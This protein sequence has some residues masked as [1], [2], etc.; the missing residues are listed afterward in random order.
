VIA[1]QMIVQEEYSITRTRA[2][3]G[4]AERRRARTA[5][6]RYA[7]TLRIAAIVGTLTVC[8]VVYLGLMGN[9]ERMNYELARVDRE[10][11]ALVEK[12]TQ[13]D[14]TLARLRSRERLA[15]VAASLG[16]HEPQ[17]F[18]AI[19][20]PVEHPKPEPGGLAFLAKLR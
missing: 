4:A 3:R 9:V 8:V 13:L 18:A 15:R 2:A 12:S 14:D 17:T 11:A 5:R 10:R 6:M 20:L 1:Q 19:T 7:M 16:M